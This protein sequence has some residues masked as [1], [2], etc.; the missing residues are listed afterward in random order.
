MS[1]VSPADIREEF[2]TRDGTDY[3][4]REMPLETKVQ[5]VLNQMNAGKVLGA[6]DGDSI[7]GFL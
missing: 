3:G 2:A 1:G 5:Q 4:E 7:T 6:A